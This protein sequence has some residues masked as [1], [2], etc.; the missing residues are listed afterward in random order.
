MTKIYAQVESGIVLNVIVSGA[1]NIQTLDGNFVEITDSTGGAQQ[2]FTYDLE[3]N[4]FISPKPYESWTL[5][6]NFKWESPVGPMPADDTP[7]T[8]N[9]EEQTW[10]PFVAEPT[11]E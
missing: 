5:N 2:G 7:C 4:K 11:E 8:W 6:D 10:D 9:E 3:N 1:A